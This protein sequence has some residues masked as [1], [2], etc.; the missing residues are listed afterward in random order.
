MPLIPVTVRPTP[1]TN[2]YFEMH[3]DGVQVAA[4]TSIGAIKSSVAANPSKDGTQLHSVFSAGSVTYEAVEIK[5][6]Q[7]LDVALPNWFELVHSP[8]SASAIDVDGMKKDVMIVVNDR[9]MRPR[10]RHE[11]FACLPTAIAWDALDSNAEANTF[12]TFSLQYEYSITSYLD[13]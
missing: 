10:I 12:L 13:V 1:L 4:I 5:Q 6:A 11:L 3:F 8:I 9:Q 7:V 2:A